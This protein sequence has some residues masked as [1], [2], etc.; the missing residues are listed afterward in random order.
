M[1]YK[2]PPLEEFKKAIEATRGNLT[3][4]AKALGVVRATV[5]KWAKEDEDFRSTINDARKGKLDQ[6]ISTAELVA[7]GIPD[8]DPE[9]KR[10]VGWVEKPD[11]QMLRYFM[12]TLGRDEGFGDNLDITTNG[13]DV[14]NVVR[15]EVI[16]KRSDV[17]QDE[18]V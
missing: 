13:K 6:F 15:V 5:W 7:L 14:N 2:K 12:S 3:A 10:V 17:A 4:T 9:T 11:P 18:E 16:D 1:N 8:V